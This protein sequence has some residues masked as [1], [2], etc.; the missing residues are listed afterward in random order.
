MHGASLEI[1][2]GPE[3]G[4]L[5]P[6]GSRVTL[7][8]SPGC[9]VVLDD[10]M[11]SRLHAEVLRVGETLLL[12][13]LDSHNGSFVDGR[14]VGER[15]IVPGVIIRLGSTRLRIVVPGQ[16]MTYHLERDG[17][18]TAAAKVEFRTASV[19]G[20]LDSLM[21]GLSPSM[22]IEALQRARERVAAVYRA[23]QAIA[24]RRRPADLFETV[25]EEV[26]GL[27]PAQSGMIFLLHK[28]CDDA[29]PEF[30][31]TRDGKPPAPPVLDCALRRALEQREVALV[32]MPRTSGGGPVVTAAMC[33]P[34]QCGD[35]VLG[36]LYV[37]TDHRRGFT[38]ADV[39]LLAAL[40]GPAAVAL[41]NA[42]LV[43]ELEQAYHET[44]VALA[45]A[46]E[47]R[48]HYTVGHTWRVTRLAVAVARKL[49]WDE[50]RIRTTEMGGVLHDIGKIAVDDAV[51][52]KPGRLSPEEFEAIRVH[53]ERGAW[54][55][56]DVPF[57]HPLVP[58]CLHHHE[59]WDGGGYPH[60]LSGTDIPIEGRLTAVADAFDAM[61]SN[62]HYRTAR[63]PE[64]AIKEIRRCRGAHFD[65]DIADALVDCY[66]EGTIKFILQDYLRGEQS[67]ACPFCSTHIRRPEGEESGTI[68]TC[69]VC[70]RQVRMC[71][72]GLSWRGELAARP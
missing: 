5:V 54:L 22:S 1:L 41:R 57:L 6:L 34:M 20:A 67:V 43:E 13:D 24:G 31:R 37:E 60:G 70:H 61:T 40:A 33:A 35:E 53:P 55:M 68:V 23:N 25:L 38:K 2:C 9:S 49:D 26:F 36:A 45:N 71:R 7:G 17:S 64:E 14:R 39:E 27:L 28:G 48:D 10:P 59:R 47:L 46:I 42:R 51:L 19:Q 44:L 62:R 72:E 15:A 3:R 30:G 21:T 69:P 16:G 63:T 52:R 12:R 58:Y 8:R 11:V 66:E 29:V 56:R 4:K 65:P 18:T 32:R 50:A